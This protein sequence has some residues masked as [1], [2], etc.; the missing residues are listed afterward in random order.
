MTLRLLVTTLRV[1]ICCTSQSKTVFDVSTGQC[2]LNSGLETLSRQT[3]FS[4]PNKIFIH[5]P[6]FAQQS[7]TVFHRDVYK[8]Q[9]LLPL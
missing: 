3:H 9:I 6:L 2:T 4:E 7:W 1:F 5:F 8:R